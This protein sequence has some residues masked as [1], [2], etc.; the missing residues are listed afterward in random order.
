MQITDPDSSTPTFTLVSQANGPTTT[1]NDAT[2]CQVQSV[3]LGISKS[4]PA[5]V[6]AGGQITWTLTVTNE[7]LGVSSGYTVT[8]EV[9]ASVTGVTTSTPGCS[10]TDNTVVCVGGVMQP[11]EVATITITGTAPATVGTT[12]SNRDRPRERG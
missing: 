5:T 6:P 2:S 8:D 11:G 12:L 7:S 1:N 4:G 9:P 3:N 10:V